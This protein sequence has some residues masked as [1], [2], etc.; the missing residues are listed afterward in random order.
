MPVSEVSPDGVAAVMPPS[1][2]LGMGSSPGCKEGSVRALSA[3]HRALAVLWA[4]L[5]QSCRDG[6][7]QRLPTQRAGAAISYQ[8]RAICP[9]G[10]ALAAASTCGPGWSRKGWHIPSCLGSDSFPLTSQPALMPQAGAFGSVC[11]VLSQRPLQQ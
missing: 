6:S 10:W 3:G 8:G 9:P 5:T 4:Q 11:F 7:R 1:P 2:F